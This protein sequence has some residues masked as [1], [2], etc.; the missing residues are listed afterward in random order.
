V[1]V[2]ELKWKAAGRLE[3]LELNFNSSSEQRRGEK[4]KNGHA[5]TGLKEAFT[6]KIGKTKRTRDVEQ[7]RNKSLHSI[8]PP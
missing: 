6:S 1:K 7:D 3:A 5:I 4:K 2:L 8:S